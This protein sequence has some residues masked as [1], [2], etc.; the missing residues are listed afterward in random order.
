MLQLH[1]IAINMHAGRLLFTV[2]LLLSLA[3]ALFGGFGISRFFHRWRVKAGTSL[4]EIFFGLLESI[5]IPLL[6]LLTLYIAMEVLTPP[7]RIEHIASKVCLGLVVTLIFYFLARAIVLVLQHV[8]QR[9]AGLKRVTHPAT[10]VV[11]L[12]FAILA[13]VIILENLGIHLTAVWTTLGVGSV[14]VA[15]ALQ[16]TLSNFFAGLY[17]LADRPLNSGDYVK[18][19]S[20]FEGYVLQVGWRAT[21]IRTLQN[22]VVFVPNSS[23]AKATLVNY[24]LPDERIAISIKVGV[25]YGTDPAKVETE[26]LDIAQQAGRDG[27]DGFLALPEPSVRLIPGFGDSTLDFTLNVSVRRFVDQYLVQS[28]LRKRII[29][30]FT[31]EGIEMPFPTRTLLLDKSVTDLLKD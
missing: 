24:S 8:G 14:A 13:T 25:A 11:R 3:A 5:P 22:T 6:I 21:S 29:D 28:E 12:L 10:L 19:D 7:P 1:S 26:L 30:R 17:L 2:V 23:L 15:L 27:L 9:D 4:A 31:K 20:G 18:V 16:E